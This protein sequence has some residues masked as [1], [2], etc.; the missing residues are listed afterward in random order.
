MSKP[1]RWITVVAISLAWVS[2]ASAHGGGLDGQG[3]H[4]ERKTGGYHC[5]GGGGAVPGQAA[6]PVQQAI[7]PTCYVG[8]EGGTYTLTPSGKKNYKGC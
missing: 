2:V 6:A 5:H 3:C 7:P 1:L 4:H 8:P